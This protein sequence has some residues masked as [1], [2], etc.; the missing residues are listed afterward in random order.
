MEV[1]FSTRK[2]QRDC[3]AEREM[4]RRWGKPL[5]KK[6]QQRLTELDGAQTLADM[7][8]LPA[9]RCHELK[10]NRKG[11]LS[12]DLAHPYRL[13]FVPDHDP[14]PLKPDRGL[15]WAA[16]TRVLILEVTDTH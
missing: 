1:M 4:V 9:A 13:I 12:V 7:S 11:Q 2:M 6:L 14:V 16:V 8:R 15:D 3:S 10:L 5:A